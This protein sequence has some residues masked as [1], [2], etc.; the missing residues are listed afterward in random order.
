MLCLHGAFD[1]GRMWD[2]LAPAIAALG[3]RVVAVDLRGHGD[4]GRLGSGH[5]WFA[6]ALDIGLLAR[7]FGRPVGLVGHS[8]GGGAAVYGPACGPSWC[9]GS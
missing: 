6:T 4:S 2:G 3:F 1:H 9:R 8:F 7:S 5:V